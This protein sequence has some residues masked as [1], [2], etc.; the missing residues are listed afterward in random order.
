M[1]R[2]GILGLPG[3][4]ADQVSWACLSW[5]V[6]GA[7]H[8]DKAAIARPAVMM[9]FI[10][11]SFSRRQRS[12]A[13]TRGTLGSIRGGA[14]MRTPSKRGRT[15][16]YV[17]SGDRRTIEQRGRLTRQALEDLGDT[18]RDRRRGL[19]NRR[20][21]GRNR[22]NA[23]HGAARSLRSLAAM[24]MPSVIMR[25][26]AGIGVVLMF[27]AMLVRD[28]RRMHRLYTVMNMRGAG[29]RRLGHQAR[30]GIAKRQRRAGR[31]HAKQIEQGGKPPCLG[32]LGPCQ[33][34]EHGG[35]LMPSA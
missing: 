12:A 32:A 22:R 29:G 1:V 8:A 15:H 17:G 35:N 31:E 18:E 30:R 16:R 4:P 21:I 25:G 13:A 6:A 14:G 9:F 19:G 11:C 20:Q 10:R 34:N 5:L 26:A 24:L 23:H 2:E 27:F 7:G 33:A 28:A 3:S